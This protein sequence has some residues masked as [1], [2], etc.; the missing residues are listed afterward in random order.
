[1]KKSPEH[2][3]LEQVR[4]LLARAKALLDRLRGSINRPDRERGANR[5]RTEDAEAVLQAHVYILLVYYNVKSNLEKS[6]ADTPSTKL[7]HEKANE[8]LSIINLALYY[9]ENTRPTS[10][11]KATLP[12]PNILR[13]N[14][15]WLKQVQDSL[16]YPFTPETIEL[17]YHPEF[18]YSLKLMGLASDGD[19]IE[20]EAQRAIEKDSN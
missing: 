8:L 5:E 20:S 14:I 10:S 4:N 3:P 18:N 7:R 17:L 1:M 16:H 19:M 11:L 9:L 15:L 2:S 12:E 6:T 13:D